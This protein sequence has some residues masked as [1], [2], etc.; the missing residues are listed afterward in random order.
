MTAT[1]V[2]LSNFFHL[3]NATTSSI[4]AVVTTVALFIRMLGL[5]I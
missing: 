4:I 1:S 3:R 2:I 5:W